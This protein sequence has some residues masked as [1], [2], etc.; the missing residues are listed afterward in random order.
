MELL[1]VGLTQP[2]FFG[3][4]VGEL[5]TAL[6]PQVQIVALRRGDYNRP[7]SLN[8]VIAENDV[9][10]AVGPTRA[11]LDQVQTILGQ[12]S[13]GAITADRRDLDYLRVFASR[14]SVICLLYTSPSPR[15]S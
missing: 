11:V 3:K 9:L 2:E 8:S 4:R 12:P 15:D 7:A 13:H 5:M 1:E 14:P 6:P 10:L